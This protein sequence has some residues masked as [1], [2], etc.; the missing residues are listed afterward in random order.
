M[1]VLKRVSLVWGPYGDPDSDV[2][3]DV[4]R[5]YL[6]DPSHVAFCDSESGVIWL[7]R[8]EAIPGHEALY[9]KSGRALRL[10]TSDD[11][12]IGK[13][14]DSL[15]SMTALEFVTRVLL[16]QGLDIELCPA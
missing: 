3:Y 16:P 9:V 4:V 6:W 11:E 8:A 13:L 1:T 10:G 12:A 7:V 14:Y 15:T 2:D 5:S